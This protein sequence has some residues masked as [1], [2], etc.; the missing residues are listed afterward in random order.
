MFWFLHQNST[1]KFEIIYTYL[2]IFQLFQIHIPSF[3]KQCWA[4]AWHPERRKS[5]KSNIISF[6]KGID[7]NFLNFW[8]YSKFFN[9][10]K[11]IHIFLFLDKFFGM[12][13]TTCELWVFCLFVCLFVG[14]R[15]LVHVPE[16]GNWIPLSLHFLG[17]FSLLMC[18]ALLSKLASLLS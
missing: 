8:V 6:N 3:S 9:F 2:H 18:L 5:G 17:V 7:F 16:P 1:G 15:G 4:M 10:L 11:L 13:Y 14:R 12:Q